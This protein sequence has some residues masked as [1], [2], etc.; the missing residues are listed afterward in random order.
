MGGYP[1]LPGIEI[2]ACGPLCEVSFWGF[3]RRVDPDLTGQDQG[4]EGLDARNNPDA[5]N[6]QLSRVR[7]RVTAG[8]GNLPA[9]QPADTVL[10]QSRLVISPSVSLGNHTRHAML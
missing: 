5:H 10:R 7:C 9:D 8:I 1:W 4:A 6:R 2:V 3:R